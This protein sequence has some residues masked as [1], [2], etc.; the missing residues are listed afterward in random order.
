QIALLDRLFNERPTPV[1]FGSPQLLTLSKML[2][3]ALNNNMAS[4]AN[5]TRFGK[6]DELTNMDEA[7]HQ[8]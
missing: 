1:M 7:F 4:L 5:D 3:T 6:G 8:C 2:R